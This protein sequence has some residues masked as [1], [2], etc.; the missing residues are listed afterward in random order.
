[1]KSAVD[2]DPLSVESY[3]A[4]HKGV[5][6]WELDIRK[7]TVT[8]VLRS[9]SLRPGQLD[10]LAGCPPCQGFSSM[11]TLNRSRSVHDERNDL[12]FEFIRFARGL[13]PKTIMMENVPGLAKDHRMR[14]F[15][16]SLEALG[17]RSEY[18]VL[19]A[20]NYGVPQRRKRLIL[21]AARGGEVPAFAAPDPQ[22]TTVHQA[23]SSLPPPGSSDDPLHIVAEKR[24][25]RIQKL[26]VS[27]PK[28][29]GSR[30]SL[31]DEFRL[32]CHRTCDGF[33]DVYGRMSW[34]EPAPTITGGC[35]NPS[36]GR[37]LHPSHD[38]AVTLREAAMLQA[39]PSDYRF[40]LR[41]GRYGVA[42]LIGNALPPEFVRRHAREV[43]LHLQRRL[44][45]RRSNDND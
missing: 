21:L 35:I 15:V 26:I 30:S 19:D 22:W 6:V 32:R 16:E 28:D 5:R 42:R 25:D 8:L 23:I 10:L 39:F 13:K 44:K 45:T 27:V 20:A 29:G 43:R 14:S 18:R 2:V 34:Q 40:S 31:G 37:F 17:Y 41:R 7:L 3:R 36:K 12:L 24:S 4:N 9:L 11:R 38:R 1:M 33:K